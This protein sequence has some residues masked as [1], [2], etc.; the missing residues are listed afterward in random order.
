MALYLQIWDLR[1]SYE[2]VLREKQF[3]DY[4]SDIAVDR[5]KRWIFVTSA[6]GTVATYN[7]RQ[8]KYVMLSD[9]LECEVMSAQIMKVSP[10]KK[11][12][13]YAMCGC[14]W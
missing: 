5:G 9:N 10:Y 8:R 14:V 7:A 4:I 3:E 13:H 11:S 12:I 6:E 2:A 1:K